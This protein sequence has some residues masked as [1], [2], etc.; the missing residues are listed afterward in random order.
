M[1]IKT[2]RTQG[3]K[4]SK[5]LLSPE[6]ISKLKTRIHLKVRQE[7]VQD[8]IKYSYENILFTAGKIYSSVC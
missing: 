2:H 3:K 8:V 6:Q 4:K 7:D 5:K 1:D